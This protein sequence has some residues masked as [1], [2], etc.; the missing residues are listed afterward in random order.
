MVF[1]KFSHH[2]KTADLCNLSSCRLIF[3]GGLLAGAKENNITKMRGLQSHELC[4]TDCKLGIIYCCKER[5]QNYCIPGR[6]SGILWIMH[7]RCPRRRRRPRRRPRTR[8][9]RFPCVRA[10]GHISK[11]IS[12]KL[13]RWVAM[14]EI[15][16]PYCFGTPRVKIM[17]QGV[18]NVKN[19]DSCLCSSYRPQLLPDFFY[20]WLVY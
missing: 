18:K 4:C 5:F 16:P 14:A 7:G 9:Q 6:K 19:F 13:G 20:I 17:T 10:I 8:P 1:Y 3:M 15:S 12:F 11:G 2:K